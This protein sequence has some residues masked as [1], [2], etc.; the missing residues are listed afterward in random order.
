MNKKIEKLKNLDQFENWGKC[1][2]LGPVS[3]FHLNQNARL[4]ARNKKRGNDSATEKSDH[5]EKRQK[6]DDDMDVDAQSDGEEPRPMGDALPPADRDSDD[7]SS[8]DE[9]DEEFVSPNGQITITKQSN[10]T[11]AYKAIHGDDAETEEFDRR[12]AAYTREQWGAM[13]ETLIGSQLD[14]NCSNKDLLMVFKLF[15]NLFCFPF[16]DEYDVIDRVKAIYP[17]V[18]SMKDQF[19]KIKRLLGSLHMEL[20]RRNMI[21]ETRSGRDIERM[22]TRIA[23]SMKMTFEQVITNRLLQK[24]VDKS[25]K[26]ML[27][28]MSP[29]TF[30]QE[31]DP[32]K[33]KKHQQ[34]LHF[35][36]RLAFSKH[37]RKDKECLYQPRF[38][39]KDEFVFAYEYVCEM[40]DF[41]F[42]GL[43]PL[44]QNH[45][46][47]ECL[48]ERGGN[49]KMCI[50]I[51]TNVKS[52]LLPDL[53]RNPDI[54]AFQNG[55]YVLSMD[56]FFYF[57]QLPHKHWVGQLEGNITAIKYHNI[58]FEEEA[59]DREMNTE[60]GRTYMTIQLD[61]IHA[62]LS[63][64][65]F[66]LPE[67]VWIFCLL[68][69]LL[70]KVNEHDCWSV[71][72]YFL[73]LAGT[74]KSTLL[75]LVAAL[76]ETRD[77]GYLNNS[78]QKTFSLDGIHDKLLYLAL[79]I[80]ENFQLDQVTWQS[81][82]SGE[83]VSVSR[84]YKRPI[85]VIWKSHGGFAGNKLPGWTDNAGSLSRR[86]VIIEF[87]TPVS[88][89][90]PNLFEKCLKM[91]DRFM[92]VI[93]AA[94]LDMARKY[95]HQGI[96]EVLPEKFK[97]SEQKALVELNVLMSFI[98]ECCEIDEE[99]DK[100]KK[101]YVS[102]FSEFNKCFRLFCK[103]N[104]LKSKTLNYGF[105]SG[106]FSKYQLLVITPEPSD[107][108]KQTEKY[109][110]G[111]KL[112]DSAMQAAE[113]D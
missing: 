24:G 90:D 41:V 37:Y 43:Y 105:Y 18:F 77:I 86:L 99:G 98:K 49:S 25:M 69:R 101:S 104:S 35:Y 15:Y 40:S 26:G 85:T 82:V 112:K 55:L 51:L 42:Q 31:L 12:L 83:E 89:S 94:Y 95:Q 45:Y 7:E 52:E 67:R 107:R 33:L 39:D 84:K 16:K 23:F 48:T 91:K 53:E 76:L 32:T 64:Q 3:D 97:K 79:D 29:L 47:F 88:K 65:G 96:K 75:R 59:M 62:I 70:H 2:T 93:N 56:T 92:K 28:E 57:K 102:V 108:L 72:I 66:E 50:D 10:V 27:D 81:M 63:H 60:R 78:L 44:E 21:D 87:L 9:E 73:G 110:L 14:T 100:D 113:G 22:M 111:I 36:Y 80:D 54:H 61:P 74:G 30:F 17:N 1:K 106:V 34:L 38:N 6:Q 4:M 103:R 109:I 19:N 8:G 13:S 68:G 58:P 11:E 46:W 20:V 5:A 71:F